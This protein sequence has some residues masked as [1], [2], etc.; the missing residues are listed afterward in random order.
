MHQRLHNQLKATSIVV[1]AL[2]SIS[3]MLSAGCQPLALTTDTQ[4]PPSP[5]NVFG[6]P[7]D[8]PPDRQT[9]EVG[10]VQTE[11]AL[12]VTITVSPAPTG[13]PPTYTP[14]PFQ[15]GL[16]EISLLPFGNPQLYAI[17]TGWAG[18]VNGERTY[19]YAGARKD[20][21]GI[22]PVITNGLVI[23]KGYSSD[24]SN[25]N[26]VEYDASAQ[27]ILTITAETNARL[28]LT[29]TNGNALY[30]DVPARQFVDN[31]TVTITAPTTTPLPPIMGTPTLAPLPTGY[32]NPT[33]TAVIPTTTP[34]PTG[35]PNLTGTPPTTQT[36]VAP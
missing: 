12:I 20:L 7:T 6:F 9:F 32:P 35:Y 15:S 8:Y 30:F 19:V 29:S 21:S 16:F 24:L 1:W 22:S 31:L 33:P 25:V 2:V 23:V 34:V 28:T 27:G 10:E 18:I 3:A 11:K 14:A 17:S 4:V 13:N 36:Q 5:S 26:V